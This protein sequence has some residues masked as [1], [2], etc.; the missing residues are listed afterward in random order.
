M[1]L[2]ARVTVEGRRSSWS[3]CRASPC[4]A[5]S[6]TRGPVRLA[7]RASLL[8]PV[9]QLRR[10]DRRASLAKKITRAERAIERYQDAFE[11]GDLDPSRFSNAYPPWMRALTHSKAKTKHSPSSSPQTR[12]QRRIRRHSKPSLTSSITSSPT[13]SLSK[14]RRYSES[15]SPT[16]A[17]TAARKSCPPIASA[18]PWFARR[19]V[20]RSQPKSRRTGLRGSRAARSRSGMGL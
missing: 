9:S 8:A 13:A 6:S 19:Q 16:C 10:R 20:Q 14:P 11:N 1:D 17:S 7:S 5:S 2:R 12:P 4:A 15:S 18:H 3:R